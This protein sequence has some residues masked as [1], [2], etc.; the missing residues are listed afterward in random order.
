MDHFLVE[1]ITISDSEYCDILD[2][3]LFWNV[4]KFNYNK[5]KEV[6]IVKMLT[7]NSSSRNLQISS[8]IVKHIMKYNIHPSEIREYFDHER[9]PG[10]VKYVDTY[11]WNGERIPVDDTLIEYDDLPIINIVKD[12]L[13]ISDN[14]N[15]LKGYTEGIRRTPFYSPLSQ[16]IILI[17]SNVSADW[18]GT[19]RQSLI[20]LWHHYA[21]K[22]VLIYTCFLKNNLFYWNSPFQ[23]TETGFGLIAVSETI[24]KTHILDYPQTKNYYG[25]TLKM[26]VFERYPTAR[27][28]ELKYY[29]LTLMDIQGIDAAVF[30]N[31]L[32]DLNLTAD[33]LTI[34]QTGNTGYGFKEKNTKIFVGSAGDVLYHRAAI[35][36]NARFMKYYDTYELAFTYPVSTDMIC[37]VVPKSLEIPQW[38]MLFHCFRGLVWAS[39]VLLCIF[40]ACFWYGIQLWYRRYL[41]RTGGAT[42]GVLQLHMCL[43]MTSYPIINLGKTGAEKMFLA[44]CLIFSVIIIGTFQVS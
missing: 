35:N 13:I 41:K 31:L 34:D 37:I 39:F 14:E 2:N 28:T 38:Q 1:E 23:W 19:I 30:E 7:K 17:M 12:I 21:I 10:K 33:I 25:Y 9:K 18:D 43:L 44:G 27:I 42:L 15:I 4:Y 22:N 8:E 20:N 36:M 5:S 6:I 29:N 11:Y 24:A 26:S 3:D 40:C 16:F 32:H